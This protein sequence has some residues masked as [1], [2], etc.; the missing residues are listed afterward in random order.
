MDWQFQLVHLYVYV[1]QQFCQDLWGSTQRFSNNDTPT[2]TD[3][4][5]LTIYL[6]GVIQGHSRV[7]AIYDYCFAAEVISLLRLAV[8]RC[9]ST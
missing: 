1:C 6:F 2:F 7:R 5:V 9:K 3:E 8:C 4:E